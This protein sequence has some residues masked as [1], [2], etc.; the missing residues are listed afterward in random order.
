[1]C[2]NS[3]APKKL[4][5]LGQV[6]KRL[7]ESKVKGSTSELPPP[8][9][10]HCRP[11]YQNA[12]S[13]AERSLPLILLPPNLSPRLRW[14]A[15]AFAGCGLPS[16]HLLFLPGGLVSLHPPVFSVPPAPQISTLFLL[17][18]SN[19]PPHYSHPSPSLSTKPSL[20]YSG[21]SDSCKLV[22]CSS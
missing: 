9:A 6:C 12:L 8:V 4:K 16:P 17:L 2:G 22:A 14:R 10:L 3:T 1:M 21:L 7:G 5:F 13:N 19:L 15:L 18:S 20:I 11:A